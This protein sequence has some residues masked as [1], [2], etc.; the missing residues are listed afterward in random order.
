MMPPDIISGSIIDDSDINKLGAMTPI[1]IQNN[2]NWGG[3]QEGNINNFDLMGSD[4]NQ[5]DNISNS[6]GYLQ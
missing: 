2:Q 5:T 6:G 1:P 4:F 3:I